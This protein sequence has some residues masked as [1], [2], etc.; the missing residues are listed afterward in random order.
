MPES[1]TNP[2]GE[3]RR[4]VAVRVTDDAKRWVRSGHPW[5]FADSLVFEA[6]GGEPGDLAVVF[7][8]KRKFRAIG[9]YDPTSPIRV[10]VLHHGEPTSIDE[11]WWREKL[12]RVIDRRRGFLSSARTTGVRC[13]HGEND[14]VPGLVVDRYADVAVVKIYTPAWFAHLD[15]VVGILTEQLPVD[16]VVLRLSR[17]T[18]SAAPAGFGDPTALIG[19]LPTEPVLFRENGLV[20]EADVVAG[21]KTGW[22]LDQRDNRRRVGQRC[23]DARVLDVFCAGGG[24]SVAAAAGGARSVS[25]VDISGPAV[26]A[27]RRNMAHN[28]GLD[29]VA[30]CRHSTRRGDAFEVMGDLVDRGERFDVV[31]VDPPSFAHDAASVPGAL[32]AYARLTDLAVRL[33]VDGGLLMQASCSSRVTADDFHATVELAA[34]RAGVELM[35][36]ERTGHPADHPV[37]FDQGAYLKALFAR[38]RHP[39]GGRRRARFASGRPVEGG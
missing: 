2:T 1:S 17:S 19:A 23:R 11:A 32:R 22:F 31:V 28:A 39:T 5:V 20:F 24:F 33:V 27:T 14:G 6:D 16:T 15:T 9:L 3:D 8:R 29:E 7:D 36:I 4:R 25:S 30:R 21:Q 12:T 10:R 37:G 35:G 18:Q 38:V 26:A 34:Q 13:V